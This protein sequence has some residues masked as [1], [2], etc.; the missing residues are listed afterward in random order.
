MVLG[1]SSSELEN[2]QKQFECYEDIL[3]PLILDNVTW[4]SHN[5]P[6]LPPI[7]IEAIQ[8]PTKA[9]T[10]R[11]NKHQKSYKVKKETFNKKVGVFISNTLFAVNEFN[12]T[13]SD[14]CYIIPIRLQSIAFKNDLDFQVLLMNTNYE[15]VPIDTADLK[16]KLGRIYFNEFYNKGNLIVQ[17]E[18]MFSL[19]NT[20]CYSVILKSKKW[21]IE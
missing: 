9:D 8:Y 7:P 3:M 14:T 15:Y 6:P 13:K 18:D 12:L 10:L 5:I 1:Q 20:T 21:K 19:I 4:S 2:V 17:F 16:I 11:F